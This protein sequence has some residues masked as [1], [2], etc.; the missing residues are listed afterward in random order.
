MEIEKEI[1]QQ[2]PFSS[3]YEKMVVNI[4]F[5]SGWL[6]GINNG[7]LKPFGITTQQY[8]ILR[9]LRG[10]HPKPATVNMLIER[11]LDKSSN[12]SRLVEKLRIK[13]YVSR[14]SSESDKRAVNVHIT[15]KGLQMLNKIGESQKEFEKQF[16]T[17]T[18]TEAAQ[19]SAML[20]KL[21]G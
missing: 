2:S 16:Q 21:R 10:Q 12:A 6:D 17:L 3:E 4:L 20:D 1:R 19:L 7:R 8:N 14:S 15:D 13:G 18:K 5:T 9:I 11:M